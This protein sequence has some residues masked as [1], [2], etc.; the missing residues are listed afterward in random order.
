MPLQRT[1]QVTRTATDETDPRTRIRFV[2]ADAFATPPNHPRV[3][4]ELYVTRS[5][6]KEESV[7]MDKRVADT[8][9]TAGER[10]ALGAILQKLVS[11]AATDAG[12][13]TVQALQGR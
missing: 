9:L 11:E 7:Q 13:V 8:T 3:I 1:D 5:D 12:F 6:G 4:I 2:R 10:T